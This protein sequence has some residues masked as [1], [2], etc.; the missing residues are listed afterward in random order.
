M[1]NDGTD[2]KKLYEEEVEKRKKLEKGIQNLA[3][4][5]ENLTVEKDSL[6]LQVRV[7]K[8]QL[9]PGGEN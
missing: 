9:N 6:I 1:E 2:Y 5:C 7:L 3:N 8:Q 4:K